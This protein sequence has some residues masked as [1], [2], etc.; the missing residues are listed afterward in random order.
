MHKKILIVDDDL[1]ICNSFTM[2]L[3]GE[4][5]SVDGISD[6]REAANLVKQNKYDVCF[7]DYKMKGLNGIDL[8]KITKNEIPQC[9]VF[10]VSAMLN[11][12]ELCK[13]EVKS[14]LVDGIISKPFDVEALL[15]RIAAII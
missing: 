11:I 1:G 13:K 3:R 10:V 4:G 12:D 6:S 2:L 14:G 5:Y 7:F 8:L 15:Q 9:S